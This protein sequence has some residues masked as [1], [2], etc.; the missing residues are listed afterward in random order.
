MGLA[1]LQLVIFSIKEHFH[2]WKK[3]I[4][5]RYKK[6]V[7]KLKLKKKMIQRKQRKADLNMMNI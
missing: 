4:N 1:Q 6:E 3:K 7:Q 2:L 5:A